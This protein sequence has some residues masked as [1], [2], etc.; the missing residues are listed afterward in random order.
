[1]ER[2]RKS[3]RIM[4]IY[5]HCGYSVTAEVVPIEFEE[6]V[7]FGEGYKSQKAVAKRKTSRLA[8]NE[9][10]THQYCCNAKCDRV[11]NILMA[12]CYPFFNLCN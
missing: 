6:A 10:M 11:S 8:S 4:D 9:I 1:M 2:L 7:V 5:G 3:P 12:S